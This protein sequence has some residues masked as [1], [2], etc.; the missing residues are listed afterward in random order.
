MTTTTTRKPRRP[1][2]VEKQAKI[3]QI[4]ASFPD[5][6]IPFLESTTFFDDVDPAKLPFWLAVYGGR[7]SGKTTSIAQALVL[8]ARESPLR[9]LC[10]REVMKTLKDSSHDQLVGAINRFGLT[11]WYEIKDKY[12]RGQ[13]MDWTNP[14]TGVLEK[15]R[16][17]F[18]FI[19]LSEL[20]IEGIKSFNNVNVCWIDEAVGISKKSWDV[21]D[22]TIRRTAD[23]DPRLPCQIWA[24]WNPRY[25]FDITHK[26]FIIDPPPPELATII[27]MDYWDNPF[28]D[29]SNLRPQ[30]ELMKA[31]D[32]ESYEHIWGGGLKKFHE[33][34]VYRAE[35]VQADAE[36]RIC[37][38]PYRAD[39]GLVQAFFDIGG[40]S[41]KTAVWC[42][43]KVGE[44]VHLIDYHEASQASTNYWLNW[45]GSKPYTVTKIFLPHDARAVK[46]GMERSYERQIRDKGWNVG[47][48]PSGP[49]SVEEGINALRILFPALKIDRTRCQVG[50]QCLRNYRF[51]PIDEENLEAGYRQKPVHDRYSHGCLTADSLV[52]TEQGLKRMDQMVAGDRVWTPAGYGEV[53]WAGPTKQADELIEITTS[54]GSVLRCTPE[55]KI[56]TNR[57][58]VTADTVRYSDTLMTGFEY[59]CSLIGLL[60]R[61]THIGFRAVITGET[62]G[63]A[64]AQATFTGRSGRTRTGRSLTGIMSTIE[65]V[66]HSTMTLPTWNSLSDPSI[67]A[68]TPSNC[69][70]GVSSKTHLSIADSVLPSGMDQ[71]KDTH[72]MLNTAKQPGRANGGIRAFARNAVSR[73]CR[74]ILRGQNSVTS[75]ARWSPSAVAGESQWV[76]DLT[77][78][79]HGC[80]RANG[81]LVSNSDAARYLAV[82][83][84]MG[85]ETKITPGKYNPHRAGATFGWMSL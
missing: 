76:Y 83:M 60:S 38:L 27:R 6:F 65:T 26:K 20:R 12:I 54:N 5:K 24:S 34:M 4:S 71:R 35:F 25:E 18:L 58:F 45:I 61:V 29:E 59:S 77:C 39:G 10:A 66:I 43:Q 1:Q 14:H 22:P 15:R 16:S 17:E 81:V 69:V 21:L 40:G 73:L 63:A 80:Y 37:D 30:M 78:K 46:A 36:G 2:H 9:I 33:G 74:R 85:D 23:S 50:I 48:V 11:D 55:H 41:D 82:A 47:I 67:C 28:F 57:G 75:I 42:A 52:D 32:Y 44:Y 3:Q 19:G 53:T 31:R 49:G 13:W 70:P 51:E 68:S 84:R 62:S 79:N 7:G 8:M 72:G 64:M 56:L